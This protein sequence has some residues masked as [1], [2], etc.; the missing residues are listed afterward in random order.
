MPTPPCERIGNSSSPTQPRVDTGFQRL[1]QQGGWYALGNL[2]LKASG[3]LLAP[4]YLNP[5]YLSADQFGY[6]ALLMVTAQLGTATVGFGLGH[7]LLR[8]LVDPAYTAR[9]RAI[10]A[11][12]L[13]ACIGLAGSAVALCALVA[14]VLAGLLLDDPE[15]T[16]LI[17][18]M[19]LYVGLKVVGDIPLIALRAAERAGLFVFALAAEVILLIAA[20]YLLMVV[21]GWGLEGLMIAYVVSAG[22]GT[23]VLVIA[24]LATAPWRLELKFLGPL[25]R[26]GCPLVM[27]ALATWALNFSDRYLLKWLIDAPTTGLYEWASR[28][29]GLIN[30]LL[31]QSFQFA[32]AVIGLK[33]LVG[34]D[35]GPTSSQAELHRETF[36]QILVGSG[37]A[38]LALALGAHDLTR[39]LTPNPFYLQ[40]DPLVLLMSLGFM[41]FGLHYIVANVLYA[42]GRTLVMSLIAIT[43]AALNVGLNLL[44]IPRLGAIG[45]AL[46]TYLAYLAMALGHAWFAHHISR[47]GFPWHLYVLVVALVVGLY[48]IGIAVESASVWGRL[49]VRFGL[50]MAYPP[51]VILLRIYSREDLGRLRRQLRGR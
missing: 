26:F 15:R 32:F 41:A 17:L 44:L 18:L 20:V 16:R 49:A 34:A 48:L 46:A 28:L 8:F 5:A 21:R 3:L 51:L 33:A 13:L 19:A 11:T 22:A 12:T 47:M 43:A 45:A 35:P 1:L 29:A 7:G 2:L 40:A 10:L 9:R 24:T 37:W 25:I 4:I 39:L 14:P 42:A 27:T 30:M 6:F 36:R 50:V 23:S 38:V 31:V